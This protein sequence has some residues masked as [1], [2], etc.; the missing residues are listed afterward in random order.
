MENEK[1][2]LMR[3]IKEIAKGLANFL[4]K[5]TI[6]EFIDYDLSSQ[7]SLSDEEIE[8]IILISSLKEVIR[9]NDLSESFVKSKIG[10]DSKEIE[11]IHNLEIEIEEKEYQK[12]SNLINTYKYD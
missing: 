6:K 7:E 9:V 2:F 3:Q 8:T 10:F 4:S 5:E 12:I 11:K 1:D